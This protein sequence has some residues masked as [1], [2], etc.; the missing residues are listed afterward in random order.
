ML[1]AKMTF[2][3]LWMAHFKPRWRGR[4]VYLRGL[5]RVLFVVIARLRVCQYWYCITTVALQVSVLCSTGR[6]LF[7]FPDALGE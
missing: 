7:R 5:P 6:Y 1:D 3:S 2:L 4:Y